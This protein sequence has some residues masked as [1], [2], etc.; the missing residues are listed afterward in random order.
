M[1]ALSIFPGSHPPSIVNVHE[2]NFCVRDGREPERR[3]WRKKRG[4]SVCS[5]RQY[6]SLLR[7]AQRMPGTANGNRWTLHLVPGRIKNE[8]QDFS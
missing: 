5:G 6:A 3:R 8:S 4:R 7:Q 2:L 1:F